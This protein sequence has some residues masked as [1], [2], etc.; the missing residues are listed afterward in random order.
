MAVTN[1]GAFPL[2]T[3]P[4]PRPVQEHAINTQNTNGNNAPNG[5]T[6]GA[7]NNNVTHNAVNG[8][9]TGNTTNAAPN[10]PPPQA[11]TTPG[12]RQKVNIIA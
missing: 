1:V 3:T 2:S 9:T 8:A 11:A 6:N 10:P 12:T 7:V 4:P 5:A